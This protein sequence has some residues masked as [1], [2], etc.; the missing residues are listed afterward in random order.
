MNRASRASTL[1]AWPWLVVA[2]PSGTVAAPRGFAAARRRRCPRRSRRRPARRASSP[3]PAAARWPHTGCA[4]ARNAPE[5]RPEALQAGRLPPSRG[6]GAGRVTVGELQR[7]L[8]IPLRRGR[9]A[10]RIRRARPRAPAPAVPSRGSP[11]RR[12]RRGRRR[13]PPRGARRRPPRSPPLAPCAGQVRRRRR[14]RSLRSRRASV[15]W[16]TLRMRSWTKTYWPRS[17]ERG[18]D[19]MAR[20]SLPTSELSAGSTSGWGRSSPR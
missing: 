2:A 10:E 19:W 18:S 1:P 16:A 17:G 12:Q 11:A 8:V 5:L 6:A 13:T 7:V 9:A 20:R 4:R 15:P 3:R 14:W